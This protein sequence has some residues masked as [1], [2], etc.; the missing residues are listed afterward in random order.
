MFV[1]VAVTLNMQTEDKPTFYNDALF[2][3]NGNCGYVLK[4]DILRTPG[5]YDPSR[6]DGRYT[7][8]NC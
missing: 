3:C 5:A 7:V 8:I 6:I 4:P 2:R 1:C